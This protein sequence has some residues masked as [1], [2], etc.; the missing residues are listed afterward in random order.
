MAEDEPADEEQRRAA[1]PRVRDGN[2]TYIYT[3]TLAQRDAEAARLKAQG[4]T[5]QFIADELGYCDRW[6]A[7]D[8]I[9]KILQ[10]TIQEAGDELRRMELMRLDGELERLNG[11]EASVHEV[12]ARKHITVS[13][14]KVICLPDPDTGEETPLP[15]DAPVLQAV[16]RLLKI[17][18]SRRRNGESR[19]KL[20]G[21]DAATK[22]DV[23]VHEV[24]Q[25]DVEL[26][27]MI[28]AAKAKAAVEEAA[29][30]E[31]EPPT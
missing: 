16:D 22:A 24:T 7:R 30:I 25:Q 12:L 11:L 10:E 1:I 26:Q 20:L 15:D 17:E 13:N 19:R 29:I 14:G 28:R 2:G 21:L 9:K 31:G 4:R 5:Y 8:R 23:T 27:E 3:I 6:H 18:E